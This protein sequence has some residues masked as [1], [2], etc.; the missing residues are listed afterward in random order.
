M[1]RLVASSNSFGSWRVSP[2]PVLAENWPRLAHE[3]AVE[4]LVIEHAIMLRREQAVVAAEDAEGFPAAFG[5]GFGDRANDCVQ[6]GAV[7]AA[8]NNADFHFCFLSLIGE[9]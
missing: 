2:W 4:R 1:P 7:A 5:G 6:A 8:S 9:I 3:Q